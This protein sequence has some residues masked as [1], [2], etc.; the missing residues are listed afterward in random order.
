MSKYICFDIANFFLHRAKRTGSNLSN[1]KLQ[2]LVFY[3]QAW[4][5][6]IYDQPLFDDD[7]EAWIHGPVIPVLW[8]K[9]KSYKYKP[10]DEEVPTPALDDKTNEFLDEVVEAYF[11]EDA[12]TMELMTHREMPWLSARKG[13]APYERCR[14]PISKDSIKEF[15]KNRLNN[16]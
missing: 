11:G 1:L 9:Y 2:K 13:H 7:F 14:V 10:I 4:Y 6:A 5:L 3:A 8:K 16:G 15:F 12:Y